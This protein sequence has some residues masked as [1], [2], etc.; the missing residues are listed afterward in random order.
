MSYLEHK[1]RIFDWKSTKNLCTK[2][3][4]YTEK[5]YIHEITAVN[6]SKI[7]FLKNVKKICKPNKPNLNS[8]W[9]TSLNLI[10]E[11]QTI[12]ILVIQ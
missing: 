12:L 5:F 1:L 9:I 3:F 6:L 8:A 7:Y 10:S 11:L 4:T 2:N